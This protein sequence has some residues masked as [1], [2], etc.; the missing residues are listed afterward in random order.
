[1]D[2][3]NYTLADLERGW[4]RN[5]SQLTC[6]YC[7]VSWP[8]STEAAVMHEHLQVV[9]GGNLS[10]LIHLDDRA[11]TLTTKQQNLLM[12][13]ATGMKD[14]ALAQQFQV[15]AATIRHQKFT[16]REKAKRAKLFLAIYQSVTQ[17]ATTRP[18]PTTAAPAPTTTQKTQISA[19]PSAPAEISVNQPA[20]STPPTDETQ[21]AQIL[22]NYLDFSAEPVRLTKWPTEARV[23]TVLLHRLVVELPAN[24]V[25]TA[26]TLRQRLSQ[27]YFDPMTL[28]RALLT[29][30]LLVRVG[31]NQFQ[32]H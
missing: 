32:R 3:T 21:A 11:N 13:F 6:N 16:F 12:A 27:L 29:S 10:Q 22:Q 24:Q 2:L 19:Q 28:Q 23:L 14:Q 5:D 20:A 9:H 25:L 17:Q 8:C 7:Q 18:A 26:Q 1:M 4:H 31:S 15:A 30:G